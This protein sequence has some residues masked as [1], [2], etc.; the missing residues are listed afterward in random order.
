MNSGGWNRDFHLV[1]AGSNGYQNKSI[2]TSADYKFVEYLGN[3]GIS[4]PL[5]CNGHDTVSDRFLR[6]QRSG[7]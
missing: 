5:D 4:A 6:R 2:V 1:V 3:A 7:S